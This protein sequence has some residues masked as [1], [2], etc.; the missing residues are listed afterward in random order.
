MFYGYLY[1]N[2]RQPFFAIL[3]NTTMILREK[4]ETA[5]HI[6]QKGFEDYR[7]QFMQITRR[8]KSRFERRNWHG[9]QYD[10]RERLELYKKVLR[11]TMTELKRELDMSDRLLWKLLKPAYYELVKA[12][13]DHELAETFYNSLTRK[14]FTT[15]G[16]DA[17][18]EFVSTHDEPGVNH[19]ATD[20]VNVYELNKSSTYHIIKKIFDDYRFFVK[21]DKPDYYIHV[22]SN[23]IKEKL[24]EEF[25]SFDFDRIEML[26]PVFYRNKGAYIIGRIIKDNRPIPFA[27]A[28]L[29]P[30]DTGIVID[31]VLLSSNELSVV[32]S[33]T[34]SYF[35]VDI[36]NT[37]ELMKFLKSIMPSKRRSELYTSIGCEKHGKTVLYR[38]I[39]K[40]IEQSYDNFVIAPGIRGMVMDVFTLPTMNIVFKIIKD[41]FEPP[42][43]ITRQGVMD[44]YRLVFLH[45]RVGRL[46]D[47]QEFEYL[48]Y[49]RSR[50][51]EK[52]LEELLRIAKQSI[53]VEDD[54][55]I[56]KHCYI[57]R[58]MVPLN[59]YINEANE[60]DATDAIIDFGNAIKELAA[61]N[62]FPGDLLL[63]NFGVT[64][65]GRVVFYDYDELC[66][67]TDCNFRRIPESL[68][69]DDEMSGEP[70]YSVGENDIFPEELKRFIIAPGKFRDILCENH[71][72]LFTV[73][74]WLNMQQRQ[75]KGEIIDVYPYR[76]VQRIHKRVVGN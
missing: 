66:L 24:T 69:H 57:E 53:A 23:R 75:V 41:K 30:F 29:N 15:Q 6:I 67:V 54:K 27:L 70:W 76:K 12:R 36:E 34:R 25:D 61:A 11:D 47:A 7:T 4:V 3:P 19:N 50:F 49:D 62:I 46:A 64:R 21:Y 26:K 17:G 74:F 71:G 32:F 42:K 59:I 10:S 37:S 18:I 38:E 65:H 2:S 39:N 60:E 44:K 22:I 20:I 1:L 45:D 40:H 48:C 9:I 68:N 58:K 35:L 16:V 28:L 13:P 72:D 43:N 8:A 56:I 55:V 52:L 14:I 51:D 73:E 5:A 31:A 63:K 33:F